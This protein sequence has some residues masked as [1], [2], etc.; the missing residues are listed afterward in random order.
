MWG[1]FCLPDVRRDNFEIPSENALGLTCR[2]HQLCIAAD[3]T[4]GNFTTRSFRNLQFQSPRLILG[5]LKTAFLKM[6]ASL[7][8]KKPHKD[9]SASYSFT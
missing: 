6:T 5:F 4:A 8:L 3:P 2:V 7:P 1:F 9:T